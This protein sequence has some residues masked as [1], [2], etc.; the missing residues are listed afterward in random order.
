MAMRLGSA[1]PFKSKGENNVDINNPLMALNGEMK[2]A[3]N[4]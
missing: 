2:Q 4:R 1:W 3:D